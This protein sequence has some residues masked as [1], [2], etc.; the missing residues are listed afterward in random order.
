M[1]DDGCQS[2][3]K[4][5]L[6]E[7]IG[8]RRLTRLLHR[9]RAAGQLRPDRQ[10]D[11]QRMGRHRLLC[12]QPDPVWVPI[13][14]YAAGNGANGYYHIVG[15]GAIILTDDNEHAKWLEGAGIANACAEG[16]GSRATTTAPRRVAPSRSTSRARSSLSA[17]YSP[18]GASPVATLASRSAAMNVE[19]FG[20]LVPVGDRRW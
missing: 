9:G 2:S 6:D 8:P 5:F 19:H 16:T 14:D 13:F 10:P 4:T 12:G 1:I 15:F 18:S 20:P 7:E 17:R 11:R 3:K